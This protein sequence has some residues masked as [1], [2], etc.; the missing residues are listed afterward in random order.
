MDQFNRFGEFR[1]FDNYRVL[2]SD[3]AFVAAAWRTVVWTA[4]IV[5]ITTV[6]SLFLAVMFQQKFHGRTLVRAL[7]LLPWATGLVIVSLLCRWMANPDFGIIG[8][9]ASATGLVTERVEWLANPGLSFPIMIWAGIWASIPFTTLVL[10]AGIQSIDTTLYEA[11]ALDGAR[12]LRSFFDITLPLLRPVLAVSVLLNVIFVFNSFPIIWVMTEGGPAGST[13]TLVTFL[14]RKGFRLYD[15]GG[16]AA[17]SVM[18]F[19]I[20]LI[21]S[22]VHATTL[23]RNVLK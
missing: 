15:F 5:V 18:I 17:I 8:H 4:S 1:G 12:A 9:L 23:W 22:I 6:I 20:L 3:A 13:D 14:Y 7:M 19:A 10:A 21:F 16:A 2:F 11:A